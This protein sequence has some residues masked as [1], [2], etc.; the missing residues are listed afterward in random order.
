MVSLFFNMSVK[1][2]Q[3]IAP[4]LNPNPK[5]NIIANEF[6]SKKLGMVNKAWGRVLRNTQSIVFHKPTPFGIKSNATTIPSGMLWRAKTMQI[7]RLICFVPARATPCP[8]PSATASSPITIRNKI[9]LFA[10][11]PFKLK[12]WIC[13]L[14]SF[15]SPPCPCYSKQC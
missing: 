8:I 11:F 3:I 10:K 4:A 9:L 5:G 15:S 7:S 1:E 13:F 12:N 14:A 2:M 6:A